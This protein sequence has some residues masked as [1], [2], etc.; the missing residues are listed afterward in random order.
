MAAG[1]HSC[2][3]DQGV[4]ALVGAGLPCREFRATMKERPRPW[5][6]TSGGDLTHAPES[7]VHMPAV[8][9]TG[10]VRLRHPPIHFFRSVRSQALGLIARA[11]AMD[12]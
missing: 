5:L 1:A 7:E 12:G 2:L 8:D 9:S 6:A 10:A 11:C 3:A 4:G